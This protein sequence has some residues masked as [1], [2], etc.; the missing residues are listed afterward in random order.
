M[1]GLEIEEIN[2]IK[3]FFTAVIIY[4]GVT[5]GFLSFGQNLLTNF[6]RQTVCYGKLV[7]NASNLFISRL[8]VP[9][10][11]F[12][13]FYIF[14]APLSMFAL[15]LVTNK[16]FYNKEIPNYI[17]DILDLS[18]GKQRETSVPPANTI[19]ALILLTGHLTKRLY[20]TQSVNV[21]SDAKINIAHYLITFLH[22]SS[23]MIIILGE[24]E[25]IVKD[26]EVNWENSLQ[27]KDWFAGLIFILMTYEQLKTNQ[28]L[29]NL[30]KNENGIVV[31]KEYKIPQGRL[32][33]YIS[34]P[35]QLTEIAVYGA[36]QIILSDS[37]SYLFI[38]LWIVENQFLC[39]FLSHQWNKK[40]FKN[41]P[42]SRKI[43]I[44][45]LL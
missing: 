26:S 5:I 15:Y 27:L 40:N 16:Y 7:D 31:T 39:A 9:K 30:R 11:W 12:R 38:Y 34:S 19:F 36:L 32:F 8:E 18:L 21:F 42:Q 28:I 35:L 20:E 23:L 45:F 43:I 13:H 17:F 25:G 44:P 3:I 41:Y 24:S 6:L 1:I 33:N 10:R 14:A 2:F 22:Y 4:L 37:S 29:S